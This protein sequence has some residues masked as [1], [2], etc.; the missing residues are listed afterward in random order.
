MRLKA[1]S[2]CGLL[3]LLPNGSHFFAVKKQETFGHLARVQVSKDEFVLSDY[4]VCV[5]VCERARARALAREQGRVAAERLC[6][7]CVA[8]CEGLGPVSSRVRE[9]L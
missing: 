4:Q 5:S 8:A 9:G 7:L 1:T 6:G 2:A 3:L